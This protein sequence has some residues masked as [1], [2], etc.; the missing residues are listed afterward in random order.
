[1]HAMFLPLEA[2]IFQKWML[3]EVSHFQK[4]FH[5]FMCMISI[6]Y[7]HIFQNIFPNPR[8]IFTNN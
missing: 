4:I 1:M 7:E 3:H 8:G 5:H 2:P 6:L